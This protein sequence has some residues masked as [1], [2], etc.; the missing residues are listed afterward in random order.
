[1]NTKTRLL[2]IAMAGGMGVSA[3]LAMGAAL[4][5][6]DGFEAIPAATSLTN[7]PNG[8]GASDV[9]VEVQTEVVWRTVL[10]TNAV[11][12]PPGTTI[13]NPVSSVAL[14]KVWSDLYLTNSMAMPFEAIDA[15][16]V[17]P[18]MTVQW[19]VE[20]NGFPVVWHS[21]SNAWLVCSNDFW[22]TPVA[23]FS[24]NGWLRFTLCQ[25][26]DNKTAALFLDQ[27]LLLQQV[28]FIDQTRE[29]AGLFQ[30]V[31]GNAVTSYLDEVSMRY[32]PT[33]SLADLDDDGMADAEEIHLYGSVNIRKWPVI[34][35]T[36][37]AHGSIAP[38]GSF[39]VRPASATN[40]V[41]SAIP[42]YVVSLVYTNGQTVGAFSGQTT[43]EASW[44]WN[45]ILPDG[46]SDGSVS[47]AVTYVAR[48]YVPQD[49]PTMTD[50]LAATL[51]G[52]TLIVSN[53]TYAGDM[54]LGDGVTLVATNATFSG[55]LTV[56]AGTTGTVWASAGL[57]VTGT[58]TVNGLLVVSNG[59]VTLDSLALGAD[60]TVRVVNATA[61]VA[62]GVTY[63]GSLTL[64]ASMNAVIV[65]QTPPFS[66]DFERYAAGTTMAQMK[67]FGWGASDAG[68]V[69]QGAVY[70]QG[71]K[72]VE[73]PMSA[74]LSNSLA[75]AASSNIWVELYY[76]E[77]DRV[78]ETKVVVDG[79]RTNMTLIL[80][81]NTS[82]YITVY[83]P[84]A[85]ACHV[86]S[87]DVMGNAVAALALSDWPRL[88]VNLNYVTHEAAVMLN[89]RLLVQQLRFINTNQANCARFQ[90]DGGFAGT[91]YLDD[92]KVWTNAV[93]VV[94]GDVDGDG[95][96]DALEI[97]QYGNAFTWPCGGVFKIR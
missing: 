78:D 91:T 70:T 63:S 76:R 38:S 77:S 66:D 9:A 73:L 15:D 24:T 40:F 89:G 74:V 55:N 32:A 6:H 60:G 41:V 12:V 88:A 21:S 46:L 18:T 87:N 4:P 80:F 94:S 59:T 11:I 33:N 71:L 25:N 85:A 36:Q 79:D 92:V 67:F 42:A 20:T 51:A 47:A 53:G 35:V 95:R 44:S 23:Q 90:V 84:V 19:F 61:F 81:V 49:Y 72:A 17:N 13:S 14:T 5:L 52:E 54:T 62:N 27:H 75:P 56:A 7:G 28:P 10:G 22:G 29:A 57:H 39:A 3:P 50:A 69:V 97:H 43:R 30:F 83:N 96:V 34:T 93:A 26:Y 58:T 86:L 82:G 8:W 2:A 64:D 31:G 48:R 16:A 65:P 45:N 68:V 37:P 1:M